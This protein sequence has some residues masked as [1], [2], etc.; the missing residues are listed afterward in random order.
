M[1]EQYRNE[2]FVKGRISMKTLYSSTQTIFYGAL[3]GSLGGAI[4]WLPAELLAIPRPSSLG[5]RYALIVLYFVIIGGCIGAAI[6]A[7]DGIRYGLS[8]RARAGARIG[9]ILG[10]IGGALGS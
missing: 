10:M 3:A 5:V 2:Q 6:N 7:L 4:G 1:C 9:A 8:A